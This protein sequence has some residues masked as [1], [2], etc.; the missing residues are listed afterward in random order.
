MSTI[1]L[2]APIRDIEIDQGSSLEIP[3][4]A[5][6]GGVAIDMTGWLLRAQFRK[7]YAATDSVISATLSNGILSYTDAT[8]GSFKLT[9]APSD[10][11]YAGNPKVLFSRDEPEQLALVYDIEAET[12]AGVVY[13]ICKGT[14]TINR[15][16]TR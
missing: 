11:S 2:S 10:T 7:S 14:L 13:K 8:A 15:E 5:T 1:D 12:T 4:V 3:F 9:F 6:R 16:S